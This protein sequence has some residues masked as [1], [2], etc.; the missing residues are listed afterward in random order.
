MEANI[1]RLPQ[2]KLFNAENGWI[3]RNEMLS[4]FAQEYFENRKEGI[5]ILEAGC[6]Q[7]WQL[8]LGPI[9]YTLTGVD[10][11]K[12]ALDNRMIGEGD[13]NQAICGDLCTLVLKP[14]TF[15]MIYCVD[16]IEHIQGAE[17]V[18]KNFFDWLKPNGILMIVFPDRSSVFGFLTR[19][20]PFWVHLFYYK[21]LMGNANA[22]LP[23]FNPFPTYY[24]KLVS[25]G[26]IHDY[27]I[28]HGHQIALEYGRPFDMRKF[29]HLAGAAKLLCRLIHLLS[30][31][32]L[33]DEY[34]SLVYVIRKRT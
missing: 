30:F 33:V 4:G 23:G 1:T 32:Y 28:R 13:L 16:V 10:I 19:M 7:R 3:Q 11:C 20:L 18:F 12:D 31:G 34:C 15:D 9:P 17:R 5:L 14:Q 22:G 29:G 21:Y 8:D 25:R 24:D 26:A 27:C 2:I 6:G